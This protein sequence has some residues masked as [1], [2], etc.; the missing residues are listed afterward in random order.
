MSVTKRIFSL[1]TAVMVLASLIAP[2]LHSQESPIPHLPS[3]NCS[4]P[5]GILMCTTCR[6]HAGLS[7]LLTSGNVDWRIEKKPPIT[8]QLVSFRTEDRDD[9]DDRREKARD[10][11]RTKKDKQSEKSRKSQPVQ[12]EQAHAAPAQPEV[13][14]LLRNINRTLKSMEVMMREDME[15]DRKRPEQAFQPANRMPPMFGPQNLSQQYGQRMQMPSPPNMRGPQPQNPGDRGPSNFGPRADGPRADGPRGD[16][17]RGDGPRGDGPR[18]DGAMLQGPSKKA[19]YL[20]SDG[21]IQCDNQRVTPEQLTI[22][23]TQV[24]RNYAGTTVQLKPDKDVNVQ[25]LIAVHSAITRSG[26]RIDGV[27]VSSYQMPGTRR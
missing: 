16:G 4:S 10:R 6:E 18:G 5:A 8:G 22:L 26:A 15:H 14:E 2:N 7:P 24:V 25:Q 23:L 19:V 3:E 20:A 21:S 9:D 12:R 1:G 17:P 27:S 11:H 13:L